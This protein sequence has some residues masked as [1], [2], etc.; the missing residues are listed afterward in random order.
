MAR[1]ALYGSELKNGGRGKSVQSTESTAFDISSQSSK[2][3]NLKSPLIN[4][5]T[6]D[7]DSKNATPKNVY[8]DYKLD[9]ETIS[10]IRNKLVKTLN[11]AEE[12]GA[13]STFSK[14]TKYYNT[15]WSIS[16]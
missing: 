7:T 9:N 13:Q 5:Q 10:D 4:K 15:I 8:M 1:Y 14:Y 12:S 11:L 3:P 2:F 16:Q 6:I